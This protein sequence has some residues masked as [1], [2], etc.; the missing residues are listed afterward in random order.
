MS[1]DLRVAIIGG[2]TGGL[3]LAQALHRAGVRVAVYERSRTRTERLQGYRVHINPHGAAAMHEC[4]PPDLWQSFIDTTGTSGG[5]FGFV[6]EQ[7]DELLFLDEEMFTAEDSDP[8][9]SHHSVSRITLHQVLSA[10]LD[11]VLH[12]GKEFERYERAADGTVTCYFTDGTTAT[13]DV[14]IGADGANSRVRRQFL[15]HAERVDTGIRN[16]AGKLPLTDGTRTWLPATIQR[17]PKSVMP[18]KGCGFFSA[19]HEFGNRPGASANGI[20]GND[21]TLEHDAVLFENTTSYVMWAYAAGEAGYPAGTDLSALDGAALKDL[22]GR[23]IADWHPG[24]RRMV[25]DSPAAS[26]TLIPI[27]TSVPV[28]PWPTTNI[29]L[30]GDA[31]HSMTPFRGIGANTALRDARLLARNLIAVTRGERDLIDAIADFEQQMIDYGFTAV[32]RSLR[33]ARS[34]VSENW[35]ARSMF[36]IVLR[37]FSAVPPLKRKVFS[38]QGTE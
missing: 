9:A 12:Y 33:D 35:F 38:D 10:G 14:L 32:R 21:E 8:A 15:P 4:L 2:G 23:L 1:Q 34:F 27:L 30:L 31:V 7:L 26:V 17:G 16:I 18:P 19:P 5:N 29:T 37:F 3:C 22:V 20:G 11:G 25:A 36:K 13:A 6:T 28:E 24:L